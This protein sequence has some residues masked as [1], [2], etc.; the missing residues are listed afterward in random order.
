MLLPLVF[1]NI[2]LTNK[3]RTLDTLYKISLTEEI[4]YDKGSDCH[5]TGGVIYY[6][7]IKRLSGIISHKRPGDFNDIGHEINL[8]DI[9][10]EEERCV[11]FIRPL[12]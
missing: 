1:I 9:T 12:P 6:V 8:I 10:E 3:T 2:K 7:V 11:E 4:K 5:H